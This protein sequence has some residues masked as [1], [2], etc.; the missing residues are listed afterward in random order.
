VASALDIYQANLTAVSRALWVRDLAAML[1][2]IALPNMMLT[3]D[4]QVV[5]STPQEMSEAMLRFRDHLQDIGAEAYHRTCQEA[6]FLDADRRT[7]VGWHTTYIL[8]GGTCL[9]EPFTNQMTL[10]RID[11][12]WKGV[13]IETATRTTECPTVN[14]DMAARHLAEMA[15]HSPM[16]GAQ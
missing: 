6:K 10:L 15:R 5:L 2:H 7:I 4:A 3:V 11:A 12:A 8:R 14:P 1:D 13:R 9:V 16:G